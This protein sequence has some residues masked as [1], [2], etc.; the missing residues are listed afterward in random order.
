VTKELRSSSTTASKKYSQPFLYWLDA[1][2]K[3]VNGK[4][5]QIDFRIA[6]KQGIYTPKSTDHL[7]KWTRQE[8]ADYLGLNINT[9]NSTDARFCSANMVLVD[10]KNETIMKEV[11]EPWMR[12]SQHKE[13][14]APEGKN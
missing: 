2:T 5:F 7:K 10:L 3:I 6:K 8:T 13:Y 9:Y 4:R 11:T 12:C 14:I 1:G